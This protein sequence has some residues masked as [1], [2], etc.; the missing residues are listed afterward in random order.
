MRQHS[1]VSQIYHDLSSMVRT[2]FGR[3]IKILRSDSAGEYLSSEFHSIHVSVGTLP[4]QLCPYI[5]AQNGVAEQKHRHLLETTY[6]LLFEA[7]VPRS[8]WVEALLTAPYLI[9][10][11][12]SLAF[13]GVTLYECLHAIHSTPQPRSYREAVQVSEW[14]QARQMSFRPFSGCILGMSLAHQT[15]CLSTVNGSSSH[16]WPLHQMDVKNAF[17]YG[18]LDEE[19]LQ[20]QFEMKD[21]GSLRY[22]LGIKIAQSFHGLLLSQQKYITYILCRA[23]ITDTRPAATSVELHVKAL[24]YLTITRP[25]ISYAVGLVTQFMQASRS[26]H[27]AALIR[28]LRYLRGSITRSL[29][30][31]LTSILALRAYFDADYA[32]D[33]SDQKFTTGFCIFL[34]DSLISWHSKK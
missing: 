23:T 26:A 32:S 17:L 11:T 28:I 13:D 2:Q 9:N 22:F 27:Y 19:H 21:L 4:Q 34:R 30:M 29:F 12:P 20:H 15:L 7:S 24:V 31:P 16:Q 3:S 5:P 25:D 8:Y 10:R 33:R 14:Q 6:A 18:L 1:E